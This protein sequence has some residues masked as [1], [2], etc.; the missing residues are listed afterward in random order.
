M[1][2]SKFINERAAGLKPSGIRRFFDIVN[3]RKGAISLGVGEPDF[4]TPY[5]AR[6]AAVRSIQ[7]GITQYTPNGGYLKLR[8][9]IAKYYETRY[10]LVYNPKTEILVTVGA[11]EA[12]DLALRATLESGD[13]VLIPEPS[14]VSYA[15]C[16]TMSGGVPVG[17]T[18]VAENGFKITAK[19]LEEKITDRTKILILPYPNNPTGGIMEKED[20]EEVAEVCIRNDLL[21]LSDE[22]YSELTYSENGHASI[23]ELDGMKERTVVMNGFSKAFAMTGWRLG[24]VL[25]PQPL[26]DVM[27]KIHQ[28]GIMCAPTASQYAAIAALEQSF[29]DD[30]A[31]VKEMRQQYD[32]R[33]RYLVNEFNA[34]GLTCFEPKGAFYVF[35]CVKKTG[36]TGE[37]FAEKL[38]DSKNV[39]V[40]PGEAFGAGGE[41]FVRV[42]YAYSMKSLTKAIGLIK[43]FVKEH[44]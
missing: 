22:I 30:F 41:Y 14:F 12:I 15:P 13:E 36:L 6:D 28:Y 29:E 32:I 17:V 7:K 35:P 8:E 34:M 4:M 31:A 10:R 42:S 5:V 25:S 3:E 33:R 16:V 23:A 2:Y 26:H 39:A 9:L 43:E 20:L 19:M 21:V 18:C 27:Y 44:I 40:V 1:D 24:Y 37:E 11:S 38:L